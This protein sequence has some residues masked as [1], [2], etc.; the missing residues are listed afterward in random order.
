M[1]GV[2]VLADITSALTL[3]YSK[4]CVN[5][6]RRGSVLLSL[7]P[8]LMSTDKAP[9]GTAKF[10]GASNPTGTAEG[11]RRAYSDATH[12]IEVPFS[13]AWAM[14]DGVI[15]VSDRAQAVT[16]GNPTPQSVAAPG[17]SL[18]RG[19]IMDKYDR[20][21]LGVGA[22]LY[23]GSG[24]NK[25]T[26]LATA[27][28]GT[29]TYEGIDPATYTEWVSAENSI[30]TADLSFEAIGTHLIDAIM[31]LC[32][33]KPTLLVTTPTVHRLI[34]GLYGS[35]TVPYVREMEIPGG[36][37]G[38]GRASRDRVIKLSA[39]A[40]VIDFEGTPIVKDVAC[41]ANTIYGVN[42][43]YMYM[44]QLQYQRDPMFDQ[45]RMEA[46]LRAVL[47]SPTLA[48]GPNLIEEIRALLRNPTGLVPYFKELGATGASDE[49][50]IYTDVQLMCSRRNAH[51]KLTLT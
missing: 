38:D 48:L 32:N 15:S 28:D 9:S 17:G 23:S 33:E 20:I 14:Y 13:G 2:Q 36:N 40:D 43:R 16:Q 6:I 26:G 27:I 8:M 18:I 44:E 22:H 10:S 39:G 42:T 21:I 25:V 41:T 34:K 51:G 7:L 30:A 5:N 29:G 3:L 37:A 31:A 50:L 19:R 47:D 1:S 4:P 46:A 35:T 12:E 24:A 45:G 49:L 11:T